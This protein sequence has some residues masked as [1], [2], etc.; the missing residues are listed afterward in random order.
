MI[1]AIK[2]SMRTKI[3]LLLVAFGLLPCVLLF[4]AFYIE[5]SAF[6]KKSGQVLANES[7][8]I[9]DVIERNLFERYGDVQ[10]FGY[11]SEAYKPANWRNPVESNPLITAI[12][13]YMVAYGLYKLSMVLSPTGEVFAVNTRNFKNEPIDTKFIYEQNFAD[14]P[15]FKN[16]LQGKFLEGRDGLTGTYAEGPYIEPL[17]AKAYGQDGFVLAYS[18]P[19]KDYSGNLIGVWVNFADFGLVEDIIKTSFE[20]LKLRGFPSAEITLLDKSGTILVEYDPSR[21]SGEQSYQRDFDVVGK[22]N[23]I[24][25][26]NLAAKEVV[27]GN[28]GHV[29]AMNT[30]KLVEQ[31][32]GYAHTAGAYGYVGLGWSV[33]VRVPTE[34]AFGVVN[35]IVIS[36]LV[37]T[38]VVMGVLGGAGFYIGNVFANPVRVI[39]QTMRKLADG[40]KQVEIPFQ[41]RPDEIG[42]MAETVAIFRENALQIDSM[43]AQAESDRKRQ[44]RE[45]EENRARAEAEQKSAREKAEAE[46]RSAMQAL[47]NQFDASVKKVVANVNDSAVSVQRAA[48]GLAKLATDSQSRA[49]SAAAASEEASSNVQT[50]A[51]AAEELASSIREIS[52]QITQSSTA[53]NQ[54]VQQADNTN[55]VVTSL[56]AAATKIG[57]IVNMIAEITNKTNLLALNATIEAARAGDAGKGF[58]VVASEVKSLAN[59][60][61]GATEEITKVISDIQ[62]STAQAVAAIK[63]ISQT[64]RD[65][66]DMSASIAAAV[67]EQEAATAEIAR[68]VQEASRGTQDVSTNVQELSQSAANSG[69]SAQML[70]ASAGDLNQESVKLANDVDGFVERIRQ[71]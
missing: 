66:S 65:V 29:V 71:S 34:E 28:S 3:M 67:E 54:A 25:R 26:G 57:E 41:S 9:I 37:V 31:A 70:L 60:T 12:N 55:K 32:V 36:M 22:V 6:E 59:Q 50:V 15:W 8:A 23:L 30:R 11:N 58:A 45:R 2:S 53:V 10:A 69:Q 63:D 44:E 16:P 40:D 33:L 56:S 4:S 43:N 35:S 46:K 39:T 24:E 20:D 48:E 1:T 27:A 7:A 68:N 64:I 18:A 13:Q 5:K 51:S 62:A 47:A 17:V 19:I 38:L 42:K 21:F 49:A 52:R 61:A 14:R